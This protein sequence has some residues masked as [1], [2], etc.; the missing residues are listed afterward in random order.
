MERLAKVDHVLLDK[1]GTLTSGRPT[2]GAITVAKGRRRDTAIRLAGGLEVASSHPYALAVGDLLEEE[3]LKPT[4]VQGLKDV[5]AGVE[6]L[7]KGELVGLYRPDRLPE[8]VSL[9]GDLAAALVVSSR[10]GHGASV[11]VRG[12]QCVALFTFVHDDGR[13]GSDE[14]VKDLYSRGVN[15][16]ILSGDL[17]TAVDLFAERVGMSTNAAHGELTPED[18]VRFVEQRSSTHVT[19]MVGDG[20]NDAGALAKAD[21][22]VAVG[23]GEQVN[24]EAADVL[25]PGDDPRLITSLISLARSANRTLWA[26]LLFSIGV[27]VILVFAVINNWYDNLWIGVLVHEMSVIVVILNGAR[28]AGSDGWWDLIKG[29]FSGILGDTRESLSLFASRFRSTS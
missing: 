5:H 7:V 6:G 28:L 1:T 18:K 9:E 12:S 16:E 15:V 14:V 26:N 19:M 22:G 17:Q 27:T 13:S 21:V 24:L 23:T 8:G 10:E 4:A 29:T 20:F 25:I 11:L 2:I 3:N